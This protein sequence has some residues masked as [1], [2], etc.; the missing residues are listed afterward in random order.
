[1]TRSEESVQ[2]RVDVPNS[3]GTESHE[4]DVRT[5]RGP[6]VFQDLETIV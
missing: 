2:K 4:E 6:K 3:S 1:M 5:T